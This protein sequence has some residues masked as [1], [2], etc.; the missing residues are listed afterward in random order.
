MFIWQ[1]YTCFIFLFAMQQN[2]MIKTKGSV[3]AYV[4]ELLSKMQAVNISNGLLI[5]G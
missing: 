3:D 5:S 4:D 2:N 1:Q